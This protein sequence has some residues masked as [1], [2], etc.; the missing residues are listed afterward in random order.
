MTD[1]P[2]PEAPPPRRA[3]RPLGAGANV[4]GIVPK[5]LD[6]VLLAALAAAGFNDLEIAADF[7]M[8]VSQ[9]ARYLVLN[10]ELRRA[11][12][13]GR[14]V[15]ADRLSSTVYLDAIGGNPKSAIAAL[16][17]QGAFRRDKSHPLK[18]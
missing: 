10:P 12:Y 15:L 14:G 11:L 16:R 6:T 5:P 13:I 8:T 1:T 3:G 2:P 4:P 7:R 9:L 17:M 18:N